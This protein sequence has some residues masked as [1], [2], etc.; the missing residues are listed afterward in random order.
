[1]TADP[2]NLGRMASHF[3][4]LPDTRSFP[5][6]RSR[7]GPISIGVIVGLALAHAFAVTACNLGPTLDRAAMLERQ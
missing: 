4:D 1:M 5:A 7:I 2:S 3:E 6:R